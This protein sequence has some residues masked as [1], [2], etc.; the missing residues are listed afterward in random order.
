MWGITWVCWEL[1]PNESRDLIAMSKRMCRFRLSGELWY[2]SHLCLSHPFPL[3]LCIFITFSLCPYFFP[4]IC[5]F[6]PPF[7]PP[8]RRYKCSLKA[9]KENSKVCVCLKAG[10]ANLSPHEGHVICKYWAWGWGGGYSIKL[11][12]YYLQTITSV[13]FLHITYDHC[14]ST[15]CELYCSKVKVKVSCRPCTSLD[16][17]RGLPRFLTIDTWRLSALQYFSGSIYLFHVDIT[18]KYFFFWCLLYSVTESI[19][20]IEDRKYFPRG[21]RA[22]RGPYIGLPCPKEWFVKAAS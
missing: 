16:G 22:A 4:S 10:L 21:S 13:I 5:Y 12:C 8:S 19:R 20:V 7:I 17:L 2:L 15:V 11:K 14:I 6:L 18:F 9:T 1:I 3:S